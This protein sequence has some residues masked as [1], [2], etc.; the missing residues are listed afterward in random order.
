MDAVGNVYVTGTSWGQGGFG[1]EYATVKYNSDGH[2]QWAARYTGESGASEAAAIAID[3][4]GNAY[5]TG[6]SAGP[7][8]GYDYAIIKYSPTGQQ[9]WFARYAG[10]GISSDYAS[11]MVLDTSGNIYVTGNSNAR[12]AT[13]KYNPAGQQQ[14]VGLYNGGNGIPGTAIAVDDSGNVY[15]TGGSSGG[16]VTHVDYATI[17]YNSGGHQEWAA[18][19]NGPGNGGDQA[20]RI[21]VDGLSNVYVTGYSAGS[22]TG[23]DYAT[24]KY[25]QGAAPTPTPT[26]TPWVLPSITPRPLPTFPPR[27]TY[28]PRATRPP[29]PT[30]R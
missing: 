5:V 24:I 10:P 20:A 18:R 23:V 12:Y 9:E 7:G 4:S 17:K 1:Y 22:G 25:V 2:E 27:P 30:P 16:P 6:Y 28:P 13:I 21:V 29:L 8:T 3:R 11:A 14:W 15:V 19:Y 26:P